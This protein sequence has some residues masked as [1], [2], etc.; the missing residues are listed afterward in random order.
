MKHRHCKESKY[1]IYHGQS[2]NVDF[3]SDAAYFFDKPPSSALETLQ[4]R[5]YISVDP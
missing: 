3:A 5:G 2:Y 1:S 4:V